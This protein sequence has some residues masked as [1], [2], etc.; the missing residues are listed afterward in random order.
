MP[1]F[2]IY[3]HHFDKSL[4][5]RTTI[6][7]ICMYISVLSTHRRERLL[8]IIATLPRSPSKRTMYMYIHMIRPFKLPRYC[9]CWWPIF[10]QLGLICDLLAANNYYNK[11]PFCKPMYM[12]ILPSMFINTYIQNTYMYIVIYH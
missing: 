5:M 7:C 9:R 4:L 1:I 6:F 8:L 3:P 11:Y 12:Y 2:I 10:R